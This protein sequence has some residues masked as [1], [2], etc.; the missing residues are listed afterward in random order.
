MLLYGSP[1]HTMRQNPGG[2]L[3]YISSTCMCRSK[4]PPFLPD[5]CLRPPFFEPDPCLRPPFLP[6]P[7]DHFDKNKV[8]VINKTPFCATSITKIVFFTRPVLKTPPPPYF[9]SCPCL[10]PHFS[11]LCPCLRP[12]FFGLCPC[13]RPPFFGLCPCLRP[14]FLDVPRHTHTSIYSECPPPPRGQN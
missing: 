4:C 9:D 12:P 11:Y 14:P 7:I 2:P 8:W 5:P 10:R 6:E 3:T 1:V 13:L